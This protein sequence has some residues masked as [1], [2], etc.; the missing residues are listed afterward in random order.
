MNNLMNNLMKSSKLSK[1][2]KFLTK[3]R[4][5]TDKEID[6]A[7]TFSRSVFSII[8]IY[9]IFKAFIEVLNE[10]IKSL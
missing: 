3:R 5:P 1:V 7:I 9:E 8:L 4:G 2:W 6:E 10:I